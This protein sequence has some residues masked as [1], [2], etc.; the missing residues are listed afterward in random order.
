L[1][2]VLRFDA[3]KGWGGKMPIATDGLR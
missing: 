3:Q 2:Q 1:M